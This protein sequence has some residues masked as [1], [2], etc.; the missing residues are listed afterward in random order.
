MKNP[1]LIS[2]LLLYFTVN[3]FAKPGSILI[4]GHTGQAGN[5]SFS[6][7]TFAQQADY[8]GSMPR[9]ATVLPDKNGDFRFCYPSDAGLEFNLKRG[10]SYIFYSIFLQPGDSLYIDVINNTS[11]Y[12]YGGP[13]NIVAYND[14]FGIHFFRGALGDQWDAS[15]SKPLDS[16]NSF[17]EQRKTAG[18]EFLDEMVKEKNLS[19]AFRNYASLE[20]DYSW[21]VDKIQYLWKYPYAHHQK[22]DVAVESSYF[23]FMKDMPLQNEKGLNQRQYYVI[24]GIYTSALFDQWRQ[25]LPESERKAA[26]RRQ[27]AFRL[28]VADS[29][30]SGSYKKIAYAGVLNDLI[31]SVANFGNHNNL[32]LADSILNLIRPDADE[33][34]EGSLYAAFEL[35]KEKAFSLANKEAPAISLPD[36]NGKIISLNDL[37]GKVVLLDFWS[38]HCAPCI[39]GIP[40]STRLQDS[41]K[42][43]DFVMLGVCFDSHEGEWKALL[44]KKQW[45]GIHLLNE[46]DASLHEKYLFNSYPHYVLI[47]RQGKIRELNSSADIDALRQQVLN[48]LDEK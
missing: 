27:Y 22:G 36:R 35:K 12:F 45:K 30:F 1:L 47:D 7:Y 23:D 40:N 43:K 17:M 48:L 5:D 4:C 29:I 14:S 24:M 41:L 9:V 11:S 34:M 46:S 31:T 44:D 28:H 42:G 25:H 32:S 16:F 19:P 15:F 26:F 33:K 39:E 13:S 3:L 6:L 2:I 18:H 10:D 8:F 20:I 38:V 21:A 37:K